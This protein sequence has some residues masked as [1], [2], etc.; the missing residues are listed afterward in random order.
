VSLQISLH[1]A[2]Q[3]TV[4]SQHVVIREDRIK[5]HPHEIRYAWPHEIDDMASAAGL[6]VKERW[7]GWRRQPFDEAASEHVSVY[8]VTDPDP[9]AAASAP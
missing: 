8:E 5:L 6:R 7:S 9:T 1:D 3:Q 4:T 2:S